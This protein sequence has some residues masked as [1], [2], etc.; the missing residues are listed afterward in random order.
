VGLLYD[1]RRA[2][3][4]LLCTRWEEIL[5]ALD[6]TLRVRRNYP[7]RGA[8]DGLPT[9]LRRRFPGRSYA[10]VELELNQALLSDRRSAQ[11]AGLLGSSL[12]L[13]LRR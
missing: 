6:P 2:G 4:K 10:G 5:E 1:S 9:W 13:L 8:A 3:E 11:V 12:E 7:Y